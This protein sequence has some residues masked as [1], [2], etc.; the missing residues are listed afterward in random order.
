MN[1]LRR[2]PSLQELFDR[3]IHLENQMVRLREDVIA[4]LQA[5]NEALRGGLKDLRE[6]LETESESTSQHLGTIQEALWPVVYKVFPGIAEGHREI[7][8]FMEK[9]GPDKDEPKDKPE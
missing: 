9:N 6:A 3:I 5:E 8:A 1:A 2:D 4:P 7:F